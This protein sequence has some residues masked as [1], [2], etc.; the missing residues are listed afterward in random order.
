MIL[1]ITFFAV[2]CMQIIKELTAKIEKTS[3]RIILKILYFWEF[4][5]FFCIYLY[6]FVFF[7]TAIFCTI[8]KNRAPWVQKNTKKT[9]I[10]PQMFFNQQQGT[11]RTPL[12]SISV[13]P[14]M[15]RIRV[16]YSRADQTSKPSTSL[17]SQPT[18]LVSVRSLW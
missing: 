18:N 13:V 3:R 6:F 17:S 9:C 1:Q 12:K 5:V 8:W 16:S 7:C 10:L 2:K 4:F 11:G 15:S 14:G